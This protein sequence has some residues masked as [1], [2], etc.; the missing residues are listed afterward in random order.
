MPLPILMILSSPC[1]HG[2]WQP[3]YTML[4]F[5]CGPGASCSD[6]KACMQTAAARKERDAS[7]E[8]G[9]QVVVCSRQ[10]LVTL[11]SANLGPLK[12]S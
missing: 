11:S 3:R 9:L 10:P 12:A 4:Q 2:L 1:T 6:K 8:H 5:S 7:G